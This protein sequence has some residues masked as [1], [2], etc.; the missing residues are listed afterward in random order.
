MNN[1]PQNRVKHHQLFVLGLFTW[2]SVYF[3]VISNMVS[4]W[5]GSETYTY[6]YLIIPIVLYL[7]NEKKE[8]L[9]KLSF[10]NN[11]L[12]ILPLFIGQIGFLLSDLA[13]VGVLTHLAA[14]G[15]L[16]CLV[17]VVYG[18]Q[19]VKFLI[20]PLSFLILCVPMGEELVP[21]L[22]NVTAD[23]SVYLV[24]L[25][26]IPVYREGLYIYIPNGTFEVAEAC[27]GIR[28]LIAMIAIG[29]LYA[30]LFYQNIWR[31]LGFVLLS[32]IIPILANG[33]RAFGIIYIG[34]VSDMTQAVGADHLVYGWVFFS[35]VLML[36]MAVG[37]I[38]QEPAE[39][40][41]AENINT[42]E[43]LITKPNNLSVF[44][45]AIALLVIMLKP[46]Y[47]HFVV[48]SKEATVNRSPIIEYLAEHDAKDGSPSWGASFIQAD[49]T[50]TLSIIN[51]NNTIELYV[52]DYYQD[53]P[54]K[55]LINWGNK[56]FDIDKFSIVK[57]SAFALPHNINATL[58]EVVSVRGEK[59]Q[60]LYWYQIDDVWTS[61]NIQIKK[62]QLLSKLKGGNGA[63]KLVMIGFQKNDF[64]PEMIMASLSQYSWLRNN[65]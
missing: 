43:T 19:V 55:E 6:C 64:T 53:N 46:S 36:L 8:G 23:I 32:I 16:I 7:I 29:V 44:I 57:E 2:L 3:D 59:L 35:I 50:Y 51:N 27:S 58:L 63:G 15:S 12:F 14:Y 22:Q 60:L 54:H 26:G 17:G 56:L 25:V 30:Y 40:T 9:A 1:I 34:H 18:Y 11:A 28:F 38:W 52:A 65:E 47:A 21:S 5:N 20:F 62:A 42:D 49:K 37:K 10:K 13:G 24:E 4:I 41:I 61:N 45:I 48:G 39:S 33:I 31:R